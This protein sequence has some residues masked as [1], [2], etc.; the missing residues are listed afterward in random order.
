MEKSGL[1][2]EFLN[3]CMRDPELMKV[4]ERIQNGVGSTMP[5]RPPTMEEFEAM[6]RALPKF[7]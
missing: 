1:V 3:A 2:D 5:D 6:Q 4:A 7:R